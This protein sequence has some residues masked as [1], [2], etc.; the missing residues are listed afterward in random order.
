[1]DKVV[2]EVVDILVQTQEDLKVYIKNKVTPNISGDGFMIYAKGDTK[3]PK[4]MLCVHLDTI[5]THQAALEHPIDIGKNY[6]YDENLKVLG[7]T[8]KTS[9]A[10]LGG[11]DRAGV[12][13]ALA[14]ID[15]ME[16]SGDYKYDIG[17]FN[18]EE[19][20]CHGS[21]AYKKTIHKPNTTC[22][23]G[24]DR[25]STQGEQEVALYGDDNKELIKI[26]TD[27]G[28][29]V[30]MGSITDA[31]NL[32]GVLACVNLSVGYDNEHTPREVLYLKCMLDTLENLKK[33]EFEPEMYPV[34]FDYF[35]DTNIWGDTTGAE[36]GYLSDLE[37]E[38]IILREALEALKVDVDTLLIDAYYDA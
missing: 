30:D 1:M 19:I 8:P 37:E 9:L 17:F 3:A 4:P 25:K 21:T 23:I 38:N 12:W 28:Y 32:S 2:A 15:Y 33:A 31:S 11:D 7:L 20:G 34:T 6:Y 10:C 35:Y 14:M 36:S 27:L 22:Y 18:D 26:F 13:I 29:P 5:N 24:L 16:A